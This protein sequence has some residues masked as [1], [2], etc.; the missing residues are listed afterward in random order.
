MK[1]NYTL[2][3]KKACDSQKVAIYTHANVDGDAVGSA[4]AFYFFL[5][6]IGKQVDVFSKTTIPTQLKFLEIDN[7]INKKTC[8][9][10]DLAIAFDC[11][12]PDMMNIY[13]YEFVAKEN[14]IEFDHH[15]S[16]PKYA[17]INIVEPERSSTCELVADFLI[18]N[19]VTITNKM[20][21]FLLTGIITD[22]GGFKFSCT[23]KQTMSIV[24]KL[25][26]STNVSLSELM[27][28]IFESE[29]PEYLQL[30]KEAV[31]NT[32][33]MCNNQICL[34]VIKNGFYK[35]TGIDPNS[36]KNLTRIG[37]EIKTVKL[38]ALIAEVEPNVCKV[39]FRSRN[40]YDC[41]LCAKVFGGGGHKQ[42]SGCKI[43]GN[44]NDTIDRV[45]KSLTDVLL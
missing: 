2:A 1:E 13:G 35:T 37:T 43:F 40:N 41:S 4:F 34:T 5:K 42:A 25:L 21:K 10:Y 11:N 24:H 44:V 32:T 28:Y 18:S 36:A 7:I 22:S 38:M 17:K 29:E 31:N 14:T 20:A 16:N 26:Q 9:N 30:Y 45:K 39:S 15:P 12:T 19:N 6:G 3:F 8:E 33:L 23:S 27:S